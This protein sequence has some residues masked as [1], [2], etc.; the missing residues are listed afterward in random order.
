MSEDGKT[1]AGGAWLNDD[2]GFSSGHSRIFA[3]VGDDWEQL[4]NAIVGES[5]NDEAGYSLSLSA[6]LYFNYFVCANTF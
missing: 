4:G 3:L 2:K 5:E 1:V 6:G